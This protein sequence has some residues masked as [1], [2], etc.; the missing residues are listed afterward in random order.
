MKLK[1]NI[2]LKFVIIP[3]FVLCMLFLVGC[4][5]S[6]K[7]TFTTLSYN[8]NK[9][10]D[11]INGI[12]PLNNNEL[13]IDDFMDD[14]NIVRINIELQDLNI[15]TTDAMDSYFLKLSNLNNSIYN[16]VQTNILVNNYK[17]QIVAKGYQVKSLSDQCKIDGIN[18]E[19]SKL[20][21]I[22]ELNTLLMSNNNRVNLTKN[23]IKNN[24]CEISKIKKDYNSKTE[25]L[26]TRYQKLEGSLNT[27]LSYYQNMLNSLINIENILTNQNYVVDVEYDDNDI[28]TTQTTKEDEKSNKFF[29]KNIDTYE[30]AGIPYIEFNRNQNYNYG[31]YYAQQ[32]PYL[33]GRNG[34]GMYGYGMPYGYG[35]GS[36]FGFGNGYIFPNINTFGIFKN[37]DTYKPY[38]RNDSYKQQGENDKQDNIVNKNNMPKPLP[39]PKMPKPSKELDNLN[40]EP[41][42]IKNATTNNNDGEDTFV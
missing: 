34:M 26:N 42:N 38:Y 1:K 2:I 21:A 18:F 25:Q 6:S 36:P 7:N 9:V 11:T 14:E 12:A 41:L 37:T 10:I 15:K 32:N 27:R 31:N 17:M 3:S 28:V 16:V 35:V 20:N 29:K 30:N 39:E 19:K 13:I 8:M 33:Y 5:A 24:L 23:E 22:E 40:N 4:N